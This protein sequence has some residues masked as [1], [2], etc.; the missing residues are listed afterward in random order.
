MK[1]FQTGNWRQ[2]VGKCS[3]QS[4]ASAVS[5]P[6]PTPVSAVTPPQLGSQKEVDNNNASDDDSSDDNDD[7]DEDANAAAANDDVRSGN[8]V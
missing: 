4:H 1:N 5:V 7:D 6:A 3:A 8:Y 2:N